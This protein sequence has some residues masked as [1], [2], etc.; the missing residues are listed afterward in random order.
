MRRGDVAVLSISAALGAVVV[1]A[2]AFSV[3]V[4]DRPR[5]LSRTEAAGDSSS[6]LLVVTWGP[7]LC[8][9]DPAN[10]GCRSGHVGSLG[11]ALIMHGLW[12][13]PPTE[14]FCG[15]SKDAQPP[16]LSTL[17]LPEAVQTNLQSMMSDASVMAPHEWSAHG[18]CSG[19]PPSEYFGIATTLTAE[20]T[21]VLDPVFKSAEGGHVSLSAVRDKLDTK[22]GSDAGQRA[23]MTCK[24][25]DGEGMV[26]YEV[27]ISLPP[28]TELKADSD[29]L[30]LG[31]LLTKAPTVFAGCRRGL[32]PGS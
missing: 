11:P 8:K 19:L 27:H 4:V 16:G 7:S 22:F 21:A 20:V 6:S 12:P 14:Q 24:E 15:V 5:E 25:V 26:A 9:V 29:N 30:S 3:L 32:V 28:V 31:G 13:Q 23:G 1:A 2:V 17:Q 10:P 18:T